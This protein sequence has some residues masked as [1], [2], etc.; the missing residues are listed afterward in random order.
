M[1]DGATSKGEC[2]EAMNMAAIHNLPVVFFINNNQ[3]AIS[4]PLSQQSG[5]I[6]LEKKING[7]GI[8]T[9][10]VDGYDLISTY[11]ATKKAADL[12]RNES[13]P[14]CIVAS[15]TRI[16][17]HTTADDASRYLPQQNDARKTAENALSRFESIL[18]TEKILSSGEIIQHNEKAQIQVDSEVKIFLNMPADTNTLVEY[19]HA[20]GES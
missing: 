15:T 17:D 9:H 20:K 8:T 10:T 6:N 4:V 12:C 16:T 7:F 2:Y 5:E 3:W 13:G 1:G 18:T 14:Q 19:L 11:K